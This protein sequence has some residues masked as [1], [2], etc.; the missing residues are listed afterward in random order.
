MPRV[1]PVM[2]LDIMYGCDVKSHK[3][4]FQLASASE[5]TGCSVSRT[6]PA[7]AISITVGMKPPGQCNLHGCAASTP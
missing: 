5:E 2:A 1:L 6:L 4:L 7:H 3:R